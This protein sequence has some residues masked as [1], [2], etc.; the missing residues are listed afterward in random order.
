MAT[1]TRSQNGILLRLEKS[2]E[3]IKNKLKALETKKEAYLA[4]YQ[5]QKENLE[6]A[7]KGV[8]ETIKVY[9]TTNNIT[10]WSPKTAS[11]ELIEHSMTQET[12][13]RF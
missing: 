10:D 13:W 9:L 8:D 7:L 1:A 12:P 3:P 2:K 6:Q 5:E 11:E 4:Q